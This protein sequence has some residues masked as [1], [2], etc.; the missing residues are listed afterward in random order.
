MWPREKR[1]HPTFLA[2]KAICQEFAKNPG[3]LIQT[4]FGTFRTSWVKKLSVTL[5]AS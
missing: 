3:E 5:C 4:E 1:L 2:E